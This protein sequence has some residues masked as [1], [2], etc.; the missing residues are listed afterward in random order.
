[1]KDNSSRQ[2]PLVIV[3]FLGWPYYI[4]SPSSCYCNFHIFLLPHSYYKANL[5]IITKTDFLPIC[6]KL[7]LNILQILACKKNLFQ[8]FFPYLLKL[9]LEFINHCDTSFT[10]LIRQL[11]HCAHFLWGEINHITSSECSFQNC[12]KNFLSIK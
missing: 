10:E 11:N 1:M 3:V 9:Y 2:N 4:S 6:F 7:H 5:K 12:K 8:A